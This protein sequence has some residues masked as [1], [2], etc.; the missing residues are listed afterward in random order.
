VASEADDSEAADDAASLPSFVIRVTRRATA[1]IQRAWEHLAASAGEAVADD[2]QR[3]L[4]EAR[5]GL[6]QMPERYP[7]AELESKRIGFPVRK[8]VYRRRGKG[9]A[10]LVLYRVLRSEL[11][12]PMV[13]IVHVRH[14]SQSSL[15]KAEG[16][17]IADAE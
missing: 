3:G 8:L 17:L 4:N 12:A 9:V 7:V 13:L 6:A 1:D 15:S 11:D 14:A 5:A 10:Y 2:W 16:R